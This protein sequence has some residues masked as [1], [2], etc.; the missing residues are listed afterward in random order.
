VIERYRREM[1]RVA[2]K[3]GIELDEEDSER[4]EELRE[5]VEEDKELLKKLEGDE[6]DDVYEEWSNHVN[7]TA[8]DLQD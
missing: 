2:D 1:S 5:I 3:F 8:S 7:M 6:L 4:R